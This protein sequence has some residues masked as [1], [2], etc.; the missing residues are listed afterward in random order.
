MKTFEKSFVAATGLCFLTP[1][2]RSQNLQVLLLMETRIF[3]SMSLY[4]PNNPLV[5]EPVRC[6]GKQDTLLACLVSISL[7]RLIR[8]LFDAEQSSPVQCHEDDQLWS[9][10]VHITSPVEFGWFGMIVRKLFN[11]VVRP[12]ELSQKN[13]KEWNHVKTMDKNF[14][15]AHE[16]PW[17][18]TQIQQD[19]TTKEMKSTNG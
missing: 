12:D 14:M 7:L 3:S 1:W 10:R 18:A 11:H 2:I 19:L 15:M 8:K 6:N 13:M 4:I 16:C 9:S 5:P 17:C